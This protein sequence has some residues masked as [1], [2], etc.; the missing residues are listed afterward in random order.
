MKMGIIDRF[1]GNRA[2]VEIEGRITSILRCDIPSDAG[3]GDVIVEADQ[4][5]T[6]DREAT[7]RRQQTIQALADEVWE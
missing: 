5:W 1:E 6:V 2:V 7:R 4:K 3:E